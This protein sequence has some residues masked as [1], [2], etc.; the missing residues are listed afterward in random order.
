MQPKD[1]ENQHQ[2]TKSDVGFFQKVDSISELSSD[3][4]RGG[5]DYSTGTSQ[6]TVA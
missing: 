4:L 6:V 1:K 2:M 3:F 5:F